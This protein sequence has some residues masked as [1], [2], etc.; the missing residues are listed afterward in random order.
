MKKLL[1]RRIILYGAGKRC[2]KLCEIARES[3]VN[4]V[5]VIDSDAKMWGERLG[6]Y[7]VESPEKIL[8]YGDVIIC[9]TVE[10]ENAQ[11]EIRKN[12]KAMMQQHY[13]EI[14]Y[15]ALLLKL[16]KRNKHIKETVIQ[17]QTEGRPSIIFDSLVGLNMGGVE[18]WILSM[19]HELLKQKEKDAYIICDN[20]SYDAET[21]LGEHLIKTKVEHKCSFLFEEVLDVVKQIAEHLPCIV[22]TTMVDEVMLAAYLVK[23]CCPDSVKVISTIHNSVRSE[24]EKH[25]EFQECNDM[26]VAVSQDIMANMKKIAPAKGMFFMTLPFECPYKLERTY[27]VDEQTPL[28]IGFAGRIAVEQK[29]VDLLIKVIEILEEKKVNYNMEIAGDGVDMDFLQRNLSE[30]GLL[31]KVNFLGRKLRTEMGEF[32]RHQ[33]VYINISDYEGNCTAKLEA[34]GYGVVPIV[35]NTSGTAETITDAENGFVVDIGDYKAIAEKVIYLAGHRELLV[36]M[37]EKAH[38]AVL[39]KSSMEKHMELWNDLLLNE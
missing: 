26:Y 20:G 9:I 1:K 37:G 30:A 5:A 36:S 2:R 34:M 32:W 23:L 25:Y 10:N 14:S 19:Y 24:Y 16:Y 22:I 4:I 33:D 11:K 27:Q 29:R 38:D 18:Q 31:D 28:N 8:D 15:Y 35:T 21:F 13:S 3:D 6:S 12:V 17:S 39:P 7:F